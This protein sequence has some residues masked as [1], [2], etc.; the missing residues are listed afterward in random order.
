MITIAGL[1]DTSKTEGGSRVFHGCVPDDGSDA[2][3]GYRPTHQEV[4]Q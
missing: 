1:D 4:R 2:G 3:T